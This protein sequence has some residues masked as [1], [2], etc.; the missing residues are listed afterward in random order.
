MPIKWFQQIDIFNMEDIKSN[1]LWETEEYN[2]WF[3]YNVECLQPTF[4]SEFLKF[5]P[6]VDGAQSH[7]KLGEIVKINYYVL[8]RS[9]L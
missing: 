5:T 1:F 6:G 7:Y 3:K 8:W 4:F 9:T 2:L